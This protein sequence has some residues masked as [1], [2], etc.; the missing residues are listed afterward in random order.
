MDGIKYKRN[1][2][3][4]ELKMSIFTSNFGMDLQ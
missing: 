2:G 1:A 3:C 4:G